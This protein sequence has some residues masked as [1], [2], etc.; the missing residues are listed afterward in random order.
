VGIIKTP[1][2]PPED[3]VIK[4]KKYHYTPC[5]VV[6]TELEN[7]IPCESFWHQFFQ[8]HYCRGSWWTLRLP[9]KLKTELNFDPN[10]ALRSIGWGLH[11]QE[12]INMGALIS[13][14]IAISFLSYM[15]SIVYSVVRKDV[16]S[17]FGMGSF[18]VAEGTLVV[19][20]LIL[21]RRQIFR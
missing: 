17:G 2:L 6:S 7:F 21:Y 14:V 11:I 8:P 1:S 12:S 3:L 15:V 4:E 9:T 16:S 18:L 5:P 10:P 20:I 19:S 13:L